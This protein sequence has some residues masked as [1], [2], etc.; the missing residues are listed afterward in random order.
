MSWAAPSARPARP[1]LPVL[2]VLPGRPALLV[3]L[4]LL[5]P[6][7]LPDRLDRP[8][9]PVALKVR[10]ARPVQPVHQADLAATERRV[11]P[12]SRSR[13]CRAATPTCPKSSSAS[14]AAC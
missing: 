11:H 2:L 10:L 7:A 4:A 8:V 13:Q 6:R 3:P 14:R 9:P 5:A 1:V 12:A